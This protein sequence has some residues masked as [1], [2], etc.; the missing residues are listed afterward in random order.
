MLSLLSRVASTR[1]RDVISHYDNVKTSKLQHYNEA[2][3]IPPSGFRMCVCTRE[4]VFRLHSPRS[5]SPR[6]R[7]S[8]RIHVLVNLIKT[9]SNRGAQY[10]R[11]EVS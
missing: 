11:R 8:L 3:K 5:L 10:P 6:V 9:S 4:C 1:Y 7:T 2:S